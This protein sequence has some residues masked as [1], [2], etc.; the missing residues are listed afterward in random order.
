MAALLDLN[1]PVPQL[2][3]LYNPMKLDELPP[4]LFTWRQALY[5]PRWDICCVP[6]QEQAFFIMKVAHK[7]MLVRQY[8]NSDIEITSWLR[9]ERYNS[10][11]G[12]AKNS[13]HIEGKAVDFKVQGIHADQVRA[14]LKSELDLLDVRVQNHRPGTS[15]VHLDLLEPKA[16]GRFFS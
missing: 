3:T 4:S 9:P 10:L 8:F 14:R 11:V 15:W 13:A 5:L 2:N 7:L 12:G 16:S 1:A 6:T